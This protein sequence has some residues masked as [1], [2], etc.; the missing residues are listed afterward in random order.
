MQPHPFTKQDTRKKANS[1]V[2]D[3]HT[4]KKA[5]LDKHKGRC[6]H[7][8]RRT[9]PVRLVRDWRKK[10]SLTGQPYILLC[11]DCIIKRQEKRK[12]E[13]KRLWHRKLNKRKLTKGSFLNKIRPEILQRDNYK[14]VWCGSKELV[15]LGSLIPESRG[16]KRCIENY[17]ACCQ[18]CRPSKGNKLPLEFIAESIFLDEYLN[19]ELDEHLRVKSDPGKN[20]SI[21]FALLAEISEFLHK[22][23]NS[24][25]IPGKVCT[26]AERLNIKLL[27]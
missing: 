7:C 8:Y 5:L 22:L 14:C 9:V 17:V 23:T 21:Q 3:Y 6:A 15:G 25:A 19:E 26:R 1:Q 11:H 4:I 24:K 2:L 27:S 13:K 12:Q 10:E 18:K 20:T 16:G